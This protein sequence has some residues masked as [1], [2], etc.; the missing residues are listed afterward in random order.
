MKLP[1]RRHRATKYH[2]IGLDP[3]VTHFGMAHV[4]PTGEVLEVATLVPK[5][6]DGMER[7]KFLIDGMSA[8]VN[9]AVFPG[10]PFVIVREDYAYATH[11]SSD[12]VLKEFG[13]I[14][15]WWL[16][17]RPLSTPL[18]RVGVA[19]IKKFIVGKGNAQKDQ[20]MLA[21]YKNFG[22]EPMDEHQADAIG[23]AFTALSIINGYAETAPQR[24]VI[25]AAA[26]ADHPLTKL[27]R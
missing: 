13:G 18:Y 2:V 9:K 15:E 1:P 23:V 4:G 7:I 20:M 10:T 24:E 6:L 14:L 3:S 22:Y 5:K 25:S 21:V 19:Q 16:Y 17:T 26:A 8:F 12:A 27:A 11:S